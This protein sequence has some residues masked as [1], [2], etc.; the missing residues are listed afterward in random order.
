MAMT[1]VTWP[2]LVSLT[3]GRRFLNSTPDIIDDRIDVTM[4]GFEGF[5]VACARCHDH[6][7]DPIPTQDYYSLYAVFASSQEA[8]TPI[9]DKV[10]QRSAGFGTTTSLA[11]S[12]RRL[13]RS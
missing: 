5:T 11:R 13:A 6:K 7:F 3:V 12:R 9:S 8:S 10:N 2:R 1:S 4:R